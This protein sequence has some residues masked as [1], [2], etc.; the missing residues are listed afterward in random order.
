MRIE[1][2]Q[3][4]NRV[5]APH[6]RD[7]GAELAAEAAQPVDR[8]HRQLQ[9][10]DVDDRR[11]ERDLERAEVFEPT[12]RGV[13]DRV[14]IRLRDLVHEPDALQRQMQPLHRDR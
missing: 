7:R 12:V 1:L 5:A 6:V 10:L 4:G 8:G 14:E 11:A 13:D 2:R 3:L 9:A